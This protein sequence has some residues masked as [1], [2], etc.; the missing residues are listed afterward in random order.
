MSIYSKDFLATYMAFLEFA[1]I[2][3]EASKPTIV[4]TD[5]KSNT[6]FFR[7]KLFHLLFGT[8]AI[9]YCSSNLKQNISLVQ[10]TQQLTFSPDQTCK[11]RRHSV[12]NFEKMYKKRP[13]SSQH[14][15]Q[16]LQTKNNSSSHRQVVK[17]R[18][19]N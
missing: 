18:L 17:T 13:M 16:M 5:I 8:Q 15:P 19:M 3:W 4:L 1:H 2:L 7:E 9:L 10:S 12:S 6:S 14:S 11:S